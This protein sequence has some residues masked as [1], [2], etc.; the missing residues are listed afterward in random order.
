MK[1]GKNNLV[2][3][4][5]FTVLALLVGG[6]IFIYTSSKFEKQNPVVTFETN[7]FWNLKDNLK[8]SLFDES[9]IKSYKVSYKTL[10]L[11][12]TLKDVELDLNASKQKNITIDIE[13]LNLK[14]NVKNVT[15]LVEAT[16][17]SM[18]NF[19]EGNK[20]YKEFELE[21]D[22]KRP[23]ARVVTNSY[24]IRQGGS[25]AVVVEVNDENLSDKYIT[26][27]ND[28]RFELI[29]FAKEGF[30]A[31]IIAWPVHIEDFN[32]VNLVAV[33]K[34]NNKT[35]TKVPLYIKD[36]KIKNDN[37]NITK[38][39][40]QRVSIPVLTKSDYDIP[41]DDVE[42]FIKQNRDLRAENL[43]TIRSK[44]VEN[45]S[46]KMF[47][48]FDL[49]PF[50][51]LKGSK[52]FAGFAE[53][54]EYFYENEKIDEAWHLGIDWASIR[55][56]DV[57]SSNNG[58]VIFSDYLGIYGNTLIIDHELGVQSL[59]AHTSN[60]SVQKGDS[61]SVNQKIANTGNTGA[62]FGDHL[63]FGILIQGI[64]VNPIEWM[65]R[66]WIKTRITD[67]LDDAKLD[68]SSTK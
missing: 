24:N 43:A 3:I 61:V 13:K 25:A 59:Y 44:S 16:D 48:N 60:F 49:K 36:L 2:N 45:M 46:K 26:F 65:D 8:I 32:I 12:D 39:F 35:I 5:V 57:R 29:P 17:N 19:L 50:K 52:T 10:T 55:Q 51:R 66:S 54:R 41:N 30:Y 62:V 67:I 40:I 38:D 64:E 33:D 14:Q 4:I 63:H 56:A 47:I 31:A 53:K 6:G 37:I 22:R 7:G 68:I 42:I 9:G 23:N 28:F 1:Q 27:N 34:A 11:E 20:T 21:I 15:I 58:E 18:W